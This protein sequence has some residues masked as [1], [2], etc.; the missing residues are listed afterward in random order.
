[1]F[2]RKKIYIGIFESEE[3]AQSAY[4][5]CHQLLHTNVLP[6][7]FLPQYITFKKYITLINLRDHGVWIN[8]PI[9]LYDT[10]FQYFL[11]A[12][13]IL[14]FDLKDLFFF[15]TS[16]IYKRG[17]YLFTTNRHSQCSI[18]TR[19]GLPAKSIYGR[20]YLFANKNRYDF[21]RSNLIILNHY[22]GVSC[23]EKHGQL[24]Y[25]TKIYHGRSL[26]VGHYDSEV[27]AAIAYNK[28]FDTLI[29]LGVFRD[30]TPNTIP[31]LTQSEY[32]SIYNQIS[33]TPRLKCP[34]AQKK[35][36]SSKPYR[37][38]YKDKSGFKAVI[39]FQKKQI[40]LGN[41][42]T[43]QRAAQAYNLA[44]LYLY[45]KDGYINPIT[46]IICDFDEKRIYDKLSKAGVLKSAQ[47]IS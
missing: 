32:Q 14:T 21:R 15:S 35:I 20:D 17:N 37:G 10:Y 31:Y 2:K 8:Q 5:Y 28:A 4:A 30:Y 33:L 40:Y 3:T 19:F 42:P 27:V 46:P 36:T 22:R 1:M 24:L 16:K 12:N 23:K 29:A 45:G 34:S 38:C 39:G 43:E 6:Q 13:L 26:L 41:Y 7:P 11:S 9:Y 25:T 44:S 18:L 47:T